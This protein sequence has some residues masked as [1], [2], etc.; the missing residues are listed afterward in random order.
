MNC[1]RQDSRPRFAQ[2]LLLVLVPALGCPSDDGDGPKLEPDFPADYAGSYVEVRDCRP[3]GDHELNTIR[4]LASP[5]ALEPYQTRS[6][7]FPSGAVVLKEEYE[8]GDTDCSGPIRQWTVMRRLDDGSSPT[9]LD[10]AWQKVDGELTVVAEDT[11]SCYGCH[12]GCGQA[13]D[14]HDGTCALP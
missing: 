2:L 1:F 7:P 14:G 10:W 6:G 3:S 8:F 4:I 13:P 5:S 12:Q 11:P 9:T